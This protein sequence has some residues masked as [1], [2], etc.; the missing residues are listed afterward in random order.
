[1]ESQVIT[2]G[3]YL[4]LVLE[5][6]GG[7][8]TDQNDAGNAV[9]RLRQYAHIYNTHRAH[10]VVSD[11]IRLLQEAGK[12]ELDRRWKGHTSSITLKESGYELAE[13]RRRE[14]GIVNR[15]ADRDLIAPQQ[16]LTFNELVKY[17]QVA[18][19]TIC[20]AVAHAGID[21]KEEGVDL[22]HIDPRQILTHSEVPAGA[23]SIVLT[24]LILS[25]LVKPSPYH[26]FGVWVV[27][28]TKEVNIEGLRRRHSRMAQ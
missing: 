22:Y 14:H 12:I 3:N 17:T 27:R 28:T 5:N 24:Y 16:R 23:I 26:P 15:L 9:A 11:A 21:S 7:R 18:F 6:C 20:T 13:I 2:M 1:M 10:G 19:A 25:G 8:I 4:L